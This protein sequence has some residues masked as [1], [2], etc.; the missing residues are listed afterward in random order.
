MRNLQFY[1]L[2]KSTQP[3]RNFQSFEVEIFDED[4]TLLNECVLSIGSDDEDVKIIS[5]DESQMILRKNVKLL[6]LHL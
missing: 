1:I 4:A 2:S 3:L 6:Q 5:T